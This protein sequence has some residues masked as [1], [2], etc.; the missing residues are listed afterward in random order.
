MDYAGII[1]DLQ[2]S[3]GGS[4]AAI[5]PANADETAKAEQDIHA[6]AESKRP[7][8][9]AAPQAPLIQPARSPFPLGMDYAGMLSDL[10]AP[11]APTAPATARPVATTTIA[12]TVQPAF[13]P[14]IARGQAVSP[15]VD[16][17][18]QQ[19]SSLG[20]TVYGGYK[21]LAE[22]LTSGDSDKAAEAVE[23]EQ[24]KAW[25]PPA[26][27]QNAQM[28]QHFQSGANPLNW[29]PMATQYVADHGGD[30]LANAGFPAAGAVVKGVGAAAPM[31]LGFRGVRG[32]AGRAVVPVAR[33]AG[34]GV[35][36]LIRPADPV[37]INRVEP[38]LKPAYVM[39][40]GQPVPK[41][42]AQAAAAPMP[43]IAGETRPGVG[44]P[45]VTAADT[46]TALTE[47]PADQAA[48]RSVLERVLPG[49]TIRKSA[50]SGNSAAAKGDFETAKSA[51]AGDAG[52][53][54]LHDTIQ[55]ERAGLQK[56]ANDTVEAT[57]GTSGMDQQSLIDR[58]KTIAA[59]IDGLRQW[60]DGKVKGLYATAD[61][62]AQGA[63][64]TQL[65]GFGKL[66]NTKSNFSGKAEN[67]SL[68]SGIVD[69]LNEQ[70]VMNPDG[71]MNPI[72]VKQAEGVRQYIN[73]Q[74]HHETAG[75][76][77]KIINALDE[78][79]SRGAGSDIYADARAM[80]KQKKQTLDNPNGISRMFDVDP[81][82]PLNRKT[83]HESLPD[84]LTNLDASQLGHI[85]Q[86]LRSLP[87]EL[88]PM[89]AKAMAEIQAHM[90]NRIAAT[91]NSTQTMWNHAGVEKFMRNNSAALRDVFADKPEVLQRLS[92]LNAAG[93][94]TAIDRGY[95]GAAAQERTLLSRGLD[96]VGA[97]GRRYG[98]AAVTAA[99]TG[100][101]APL[102]V[103]VAQKLGSMWADSAKAK[104]SLKDAQGRVTK[105]S[106]ILDAGK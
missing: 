71:S 17:V 82:E 16:L 58:G 13:D 44:A 36:S 10:A 9:R 87:P 5:P 52:G 98:P 21:G 99:V 95:V 102:T 47:V 96:S 83:P 106:D 6:W 63:S 74:Y 29:I 18:H 81:R 51:A 34:A 7:K 48:R 59:P 1:G 93:K 77:G 49:A 12:Q 103:P 62:R 76:S 97:T 79:V 60:F 55:S 80:F 26:G 14:R 46:F 41:T 42:A 92:D 45:A 20:H 75:L 30:A 65:D 91:G 23:A 27:T 66:I 35:Q 25:E 33:A 40:D 31:L 70:G 105:L 19:V 53:Q 61:E 3:Q 94:M 78:D 67:S 72:S 39:R 101:A 69:Y 22:L 28:V 85:T 54:L 37:P 84:K 56:Y 38:T 100:P 64:T 43:D 15:L 50:L 88:Q 86:T 2:T 104:A 57:G 32:V 89:G 68:R 90:A 73:S 8:V 11:Q 24:A 4:Y